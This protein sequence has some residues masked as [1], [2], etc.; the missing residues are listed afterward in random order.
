VKTAQE[1]LEEIRAR[2]GKADRSVI[3]TVTGEQAP[4]VQDPEEY[5]EEL[6]NDEAKP[7]REPASETVPLRDQHPQGFSPEN[8]APLGHA[9]SSTGGEPGLHGEE[10]GEP[11][12]P[13]VR[14]RGRIGEG[15]AAHGETT[16]GSPAAY[17]R[18]IGGGPGDGSAASSPIGGS[19]SA[20][21]EA[22]TGESPEHGEADG[23][24]DASPY[25]PQSEALWS[26][27]EDLALLVAHLQERTAT[28]EAVDQLAEEVE[29]LRGNLLAEDEDPAEIARR[30]DELE[31]KL[32]EIEGGPGPA[33]AAESGQAA[34]GFPWWILAIAAGGLFAAAIAAG[35]TSSPPPAAEDTGGAGSPDIALPVSAAISE[36][37]TPAVPGH[38]LPP[39][40]QRLV[41]RGLRP[42]EVTWKAD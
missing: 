14:D 10:I 23:A 39:A 22:I 8:P 16:E 4:P 32:M 17:R 3:G 7:D 41:R 30:L 21:R 20:G 36:P 18:A 38:T 40:V 1:I 37:P 9:G 27:L 11:P 13:P 42:D 25:D 24:A 19:L 5:A 35:R 34:R 28:S 26:R 12:A 6:A 2:K 31:G 15:L 33:E 29:E